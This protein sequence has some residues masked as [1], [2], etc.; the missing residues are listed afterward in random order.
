V[1]R[2]SIDEKTT[3][4]GAIAEHEAEIA[5][6]KTQLYIDREDQTA[7]IALTWSLWAYFLAWFV[8]SAYESVKLLAS[9]QGGVG[10]ELT[11][12]IAGGIWGAATSGWLAFNHRTAN[13]WE[14]DDGTS[15]FEPGVYRERFN[16]RLTAGFL[17]RPLL[18]VLVGIIVLAGS[19][20]GNFWVANNQ[21]A[22]AFL[23]IGGGLIS[24]A[25]LEV[26]KDFGRRL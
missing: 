9:W 3:L 26:V 12:T 18:G 13:G 4:L 23:A 24:N 7:G 14:F 1:P 25:F 10:S 19:R 16:R 21:Y 22:L 17:T 2:L 11:L 8:L 15:G 5:A 6:L 20:A